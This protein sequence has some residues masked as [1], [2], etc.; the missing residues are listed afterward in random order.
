LSLWT[1]RLIFSILLQHHK[2]TLPRYFSSIFRSSQISAPQKIMLQIRN[3][4]RFFIVV[5]LF[6]Y[7]FLDCLYYVI[8][9]LFE[10]HASEW[11]D[12]DLIYSKA[13]PSP[14]LYFFIDPRID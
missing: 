6:T 2:S 1:A 8:V 5:L 14:N 11:S 7:A 9:Y 3:F 12:Y 10:G 13:N 4:T